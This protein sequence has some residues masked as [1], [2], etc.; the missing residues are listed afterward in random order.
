VPVYPGC[1]GT[2]TVKRVSYPI[3]ENLQDSILTGFKCIHL[4][5]CM[6]ILS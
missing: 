4:Y 5:N 6:A 3:A 2:E 1:H